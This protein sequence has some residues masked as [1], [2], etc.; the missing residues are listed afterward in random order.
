MPEYV[1]DMVMYIIRGEGGAGVV[2]L[3]MKK[4][5][6][7]SDGGDKNVSNGAM[8]FLDSSAQMHRD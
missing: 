6:T 3:V 5:S 7:R 1:G 4:S 8:E 2:W